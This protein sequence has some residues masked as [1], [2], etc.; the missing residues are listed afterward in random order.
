[1]PGLLFVPLV[2]AGPRRGAGV[3][4]AVTVLIFAPFALRE[5]TGFWHN[6]G[7]PFMRPAD[8]TSALAFLAPRQGLMLRAVAAIVVVVLALRLRGAAA[9]TTASTEFLA[10]THVAVL[11]SATTIH[12]NY[13]VWLL[14]VLAMYVSFADPYIPP[15]S[16]DGGTIPLSRM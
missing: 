3:L 5:W 15:V 2:A 7:Y 12:N 1:L 8:S 16:L 6:F 11:A 14:P 4:I 13:F 9:M 10:G